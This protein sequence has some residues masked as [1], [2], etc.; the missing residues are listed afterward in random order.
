MCGKILLSKGTLKMAFNIKNFIGQTID[1]FAR[2]A[3]FDLIITLPNVISGDARKLSFLCSS[4][5]IPDRRMETAKVRRTG[6]GFINSFVTGSE[7]GHLDVVFYCDAKAANLKLLHK[8]MDAMFEV[9]GPNN[10]HCVAYRD[11]YVAKKI[12]LIQ[13]DAQG[14]A[15]AE[16]DF[17]EAFPEFLSKIDFSWANKDSIVTIPASFV[18]SYYVEKGQGPSS[19]QLAS[20]ILQA[21]QNNKLASYASSVVNENPILGSAVPIAKRLGVL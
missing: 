9:Q 10:L 3:H 5:S 15:I 16:W 18:Y 7:Y 13:Y 11:D 21:A 17:T 6:Q 8:W 14:T 4:A 2:Q 1:G 12:N 20:T 19:A